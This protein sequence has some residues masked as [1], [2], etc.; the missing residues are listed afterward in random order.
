MLTGAGG[1]RRN[2]RGWP[3]SL[4]AAEA[5]EREEVEEEAGM[6]SIIFIEKKSTYKW[7]LIVQTHIVQG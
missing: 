5:G 7:I 6:L 2:R 1:K 4:R 3:C